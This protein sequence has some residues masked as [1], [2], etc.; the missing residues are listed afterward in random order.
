MYEKFTDRAKKVMQLANQEAQRFNHE[1][2]G[3]EHMLLALVEEGKGVAA[4]LL[5]IWGLD[6][7]KIREHVEQIIQRGPVPVSLD[8]LPLTPRSRKV[9]EFAREETRLCCP[10]VSTEHLLLGLMR[11]QDGLA[12][13]ILINLGLNLKHLRQE[14]L[15]LLGHAGLAMIP[16][17]GSTGSTK[18]VELKS[19]PQEIQ[20]EV[21]KLEQMLA[22]LSEQKERAV[23][24]Q[25]FEMAARLKE[26]GARLKKRRKAI[27]RVAVETQKDRQLEQQVA[28]VTA[29]IEDLL[30]KR[31]QAIAAGD[32][33]KA[34]ELAAELDQLRGRRKSIIF[35][36]P[37]RG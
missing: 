33:D 31:D 15:D 22:Q 11:V 23:A 9:I 24:E 1:Y 8:Q 25:E 10:Y 17:P 3:T 37:G 14:L 36:H 20:D 29:Q 6:S 19:L 34:I 28:A 12:A 16:P 7:P 26:D 4:N 27:I 18:P 5:K 32:F 30:A 21:A 2:I 13:Q 35:G